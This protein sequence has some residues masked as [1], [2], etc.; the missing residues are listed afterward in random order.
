MAEHDCRGAGQ[1]QPIAAA[2]AD[3]KDGDTLIVG[4]IQGSVIA[5]A[6]L[7]EHMPGLENVHVVVR[8]VDKTTTPGVAECHGDGADV[9]IETAGGVTTIRGRKVRVKCGEEMFLRGVLLSAHGK[10]LDNPQRHGDAT[11][12]R[13]AAAQDCR[14][15]AVSVGRGVYEIDLDD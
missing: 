9:R 13:L 3:A 2:I 5:H 14:H 15:R 11:D 1:T 12:L 10:Y 8:T 7:S 6:L 4:S